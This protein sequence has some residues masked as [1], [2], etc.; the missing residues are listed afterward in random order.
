MACSK[1]EERGQYFETTLRMKTR[2][3]RAWRPTDSRADGFVIFLT[4]REISNLIK[5][6]RHINGGQFPCSSP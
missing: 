3:N 4:A 6:L 2:F 5:D 1:P